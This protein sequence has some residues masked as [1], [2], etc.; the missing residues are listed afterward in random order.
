ML[1]CIKS[2]KNAGDFPSK[3]CTF[4]PAYKSPC[5]GELSTIT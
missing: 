2:M 1:F 5:D 4:A 3:K